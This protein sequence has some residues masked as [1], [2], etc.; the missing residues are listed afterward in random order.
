MLSQGLLGLQDS[1]GQKRKRAMSGRMGIWAVEPGGGGVVGWGP[2]LLEIRATLRRERGVRQAPTGCPEERG[3][4]NSFPLI[5]KPPASTSAPDLPRPLGGALAPQLSPSGKQPARRPHRGGAVRR[6]ALSAPAPRGRS[7]L[8]RPA[9]LPSRASRASCPGPGALRSPPSSRRRRS[10]AGRPARVAGSR[11]PP[12]AR[13]ARSEA[14]ARRAGE[15][16]RRR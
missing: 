4:T 13:S 8:G 2:R 16:G 3:C 6:A 1:C 14:I 7:G 5:P 11:G 9:P 15:E 10:A 12:A